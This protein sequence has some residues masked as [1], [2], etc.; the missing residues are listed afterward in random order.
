[1]GFY[2]A[3]LF[4]YPAS[5]RAEY[6]E[7]MC[8]IFRRRWRDAS[9]LIAAVT[10]LFEALYETGC[11]AVGVHWDILCQ[12]LRYATRTLRRAAGFTVTVV[13]V[14]SLGIGATTAAFSIADPVL[15]RR[16]PFADADRLVRLR[17]TRS[18]MPAFEVSPAD[19]RD[20]K[21]ADHAFEAMGC[22]RS[23]ASNLTGADGPE[24][25]EGAEVT[26]EVLPILRG[27]TD[28]DSL[29]TGSDEGWSTPGVFIREDLAMRMGGRFG[30]LGKQMLLDGVPHAIVGVLPLDFRFPGN[31][32]VFWKLMQ[33]DERDFA[34]R[35]DRRLQVIA[36]LRSGVT[37]TAARAEL[38]AIAQEIERRHPRENSGIGAQATEFAFDI[39]PQTKLLVIALFAAAFCLLLIVCANLTNLL[40]ARAASRSGEMAVRAA[41]G[42]GKQRLVRQLMTESI[43]LAFLGGSV[44][45]ILATCIAPVLARLI[46]A[47]LPLPIAVDWRV[48]LFAAVVT[49]T[50]GTGFGAIPALRV[51]A[52]AEKR[53]LRVLME[54]GHTGERVRSAL[55]VFEVA[56]SLMLL[57]SSGLLLQTLWKVRSVAPGF[58]AGQVVSMRTALSMPRFA[59]SAQRQL[60]YGRVLKGVRQL[61][62]VS[63]AGYTS[64]LPM[65]MRG[66]MWP[67][68]FADQDRDSG[69][70]I[71]RFVTPGFFETL[72][73]PILRGRD[74]SESDTLDRPLVAVVSESF[75]RRYWPHSDPLGQR[76]RCGA[77]ERLVIGITGDIRTRGIEVKSEP[78]VYL[79]Y[80]QVPDSAAL[81]WAPKD[82][83]IR[84]TLGLRDLVPRVREVVR[85]ADAGQPVSDIRLLSEIVSAET[86]PRAIQAGV[87][88]AF[89]TISIVVAAIGMSG[90]L[91]YVVSQRGREIGIRIA[92]GAQP[93]EIFR[94]VLCRGL[95]LGG[96]GMVVGAV[97]SVP[98]VSIMR[99]LLWGVGPNDPLAICTAVTLTIAVILSGTALPA[100]RAAR[101][102][103]ITQIRSD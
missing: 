32:T 69:M 25:L 41:I 5:F 82:L 62:G 57:V 51:S 48:L 83:V 54:P 52:G 64:F 44:G 93:N 7:E 71:I 49:V 90:F 23:V 10:I 18:G 3:L 29:H 88:A 34:F 94:A 27:Q 42:G 61:P 99:K 26:A 98:V 47:T 46:P 101:V 53:S 8:R 86:S 75:A 66:G 55:V 80:Q 96:V 17:E 1:M 35:N 2:R 24:R 28:A 39:E 9:G 11:N 70:A 89:A 14:T 63:S 21:R 19:Y 81:F 72:R 60:F 12:D 36:K 79:P 43:L 73:V 6:G 45:V 76:F 87:I 102:D 16:P 38:T 58:Q 15:I 33:F 56:G 65:M 50:T 97:A 100:I 92:L 91:S 103:P 78:Q 74:V 59:D 40:F 30:A 37:I 13:L 77:K 68:K 31:D 22:F 84:T 67:V 4:L 85:T 20:W 95:A